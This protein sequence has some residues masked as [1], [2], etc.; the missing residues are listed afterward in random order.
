MQVKFNG[1]WLEIKTALSIHDFLLNQGILLN[2]YFAVAI[3]R[4]FVPRNQYD[5]I[6]IQTNDVIDIVTPMQGG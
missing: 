3:N 5:A 1:K 6:V 2:A 4:Q